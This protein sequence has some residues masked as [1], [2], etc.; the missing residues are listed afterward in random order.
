MTDGAVPPEDT[1]GLDVALGE[2]RNVLEA[3]R[4]ALVADDLK[5]VEALAA[6]KTV[7]LTQLES[8]ANIISAG[9][10]KQTHR[11][12]QELLNCQRRNASNGQLINAKFQLTMRTL[13]VLRGDETVH[14][15]YDAHGQSRPRQSSRRL[16]HV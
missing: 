8:W 6:H 12:H 10:I 15:I 1:A 7:L 5:A 14:P 2:L 4:E 9:E 13:A 16:G 11:L 3:E